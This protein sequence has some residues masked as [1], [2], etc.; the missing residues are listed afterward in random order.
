MEEAEAVSRRVHDEL[1]RL[2]VD[3]ATVE[4]GPSYGATG[5]PPSTRTPTERGRMGS[6]PV[7]EDQDRS[8]KRGGMIGRSGEPRAGVASFV[9]EYGRPGHHA[10]VRP[11]PRC[12]ARPIGEI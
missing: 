5:T 11:G 6:C 10:R 7:R 3:H 12:A 4:L 9:D 8:G 1:S 2:G